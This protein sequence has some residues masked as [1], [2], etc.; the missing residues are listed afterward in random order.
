MTSQIPPPLASKHGSVPSCL[1]CEHCGKKTEGVEPE[2]GRAL[3]YCPECLATRRRQ[4]GD[5]PT[6]LSLLT[7][8]LR[9]YE[10][11]YGYEP[12]PACKVEPA[13]GTALRPCKRCGLNTTGV[14]DGKGHVVGLCPP[15]FLESQRIIG[16]PPTERRQLLYHLGDLDAHELEALVWSD[17]RRAAWQGLRGV[18]RVILCAMCHVGQL[19]PGEQFKFVELPQA[20]V[21]CVQQTS[22]AGLFTTVGLCVRRMLGDID[23]LGIIYEI[24]QWEE[25]EAE[26]PD[27]PLAS[28][29]V[30]C[31][32]DALVAII[33][34][35]LDV[36]LGT[37]ALGRLK[38]MGGRGK[39][40]DVC[41]GV[42]DLPGACW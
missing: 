31:S 3:A 8:A 14:E 32:R 4:L 15:C 30:V 40:T 38:A 11:R 42:G 2:P 33:Y 6:S 27:E 9:E 21:D 16:G 10:E 7:A 13:C 41:R 12:S 18:D 22:R 37:Y 35:C 36:L 17:E 24:F 26:V 19:W 29:V 28:F 1:K 5:A 23:R 25:F 20:V 39:L 34:E